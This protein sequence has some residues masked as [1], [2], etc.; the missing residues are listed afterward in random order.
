MGISGTSRIG[1]PKTAE[2]QLTSKLVSLAVKQERFDESGFVDLAAWITCDLSLVAIDEH[3]EV[4]FSSSEEELAD[5]VLE[6]SS[7]TTRTLSFAEKN[8]MEVMV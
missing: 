3:V 4:V 1:S 8:Q 5:E 7:A 2:P 6:V